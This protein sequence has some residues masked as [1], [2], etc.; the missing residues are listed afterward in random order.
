MI[1]RD[2]V[3]ATPLAGPSGEPVKAEGLALDPD[4]HSHAW[5]ALDPDDPDQP[6]MLLDVEL[7]GPW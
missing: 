7:I 4:R 5:I 3:R 2:G 6:A 1:S